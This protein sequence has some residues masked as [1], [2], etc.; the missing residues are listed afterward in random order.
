MGL[1]TRHITRLG[2][3]EKWIYQGSR[4]EQLAEAG[5]DLDN[6]VRV[7]RHIMDNTALPAAITA[8]VPL[9]TS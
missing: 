3:P 1:D 8:P 2:L 6:I 4:D 9:P 5:L 7:L